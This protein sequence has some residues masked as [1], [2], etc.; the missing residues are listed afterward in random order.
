LINSYY[1]HIHDSEG[2]YDYPSFEEMCKYSRNHIESIAKEPVS[3]TQISKQIIRLHIG[4]REVHFPI[5]TIKILNYMCR[6]SE[7]E[8]HIDD[9]IINALSTAHDLIDVSKKNIKD[10]IEVWNKFCGTK[11]ELQITLEGDFLWI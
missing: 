1:S 6:F 9:I 10:K 2:F 8:C 3:L 11:K 4:K 7:Y 5:Q